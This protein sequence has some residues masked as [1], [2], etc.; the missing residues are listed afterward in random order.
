MIIKNGREPGKRKEFAWFTAEKECPGGYLRERRRPG[1][2]LVMV[3]GA[4]QL[5]GP[6]WIS[7]G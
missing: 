6:G 4:G 2:R 3:P 1:G 5:A 7:I